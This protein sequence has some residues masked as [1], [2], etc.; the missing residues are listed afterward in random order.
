MARHEEMGFNPNE[1][2]DR[3]GSKADLANYIQIEA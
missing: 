3:L 1:M 2:F